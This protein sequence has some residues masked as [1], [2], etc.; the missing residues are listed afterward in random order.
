MED[1]LMGTLPPQQRLQTQT[2]ELPRTKPESKEIADMQEE[3]RTA[4]PSYVQRQNFL[5]CLEVQRCVSS[6]KFVSD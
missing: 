6:G 3:V 2:Q 1:K 5:V 4:G